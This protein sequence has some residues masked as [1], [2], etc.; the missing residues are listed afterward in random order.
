VEVPMM[1]LYHA[2]VSEK[3]GT[4]LQFAVAGK[5]VPQMAKTSLYVS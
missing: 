2:H 4:G 5:C 1:D 3:Y